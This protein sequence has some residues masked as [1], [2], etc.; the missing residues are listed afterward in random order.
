MTLIYS[1]VNRFVNNLKKS[2]VKRDV[3]NTL[4]AGEI[5]YAKFMWIKNNQKQL[6]EESNFKELK[7]SLNLSEDDT[8]MV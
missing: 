1:W 2:I 6:R 8:V 7:C 4:S 5:S 3:S